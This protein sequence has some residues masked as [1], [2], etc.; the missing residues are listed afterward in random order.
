MAKA[1]RKADD[2]AVE[3]TTGGSYEVRF[4]ND[5]FGAGA[6]TLA[7]LLRDI[8]GSDEPR[9]MLVADSNVVQRAEGLGM[10][11]G[12][13]VQT[14]GVRLAGAPVVIGG[15][16][17]VKCDCSQSL[18]K[19][20][21]AAVEARIGA[22]DAMVVIG[23]G[24]VTD[25]ASYVAVQTRG[26][27]PIVRIPT[28]VAAMVDGAFSEYA[29]I[30]LAGVKDA[31]RIPCRPSG[32]VID[33]T[34]AST[35]L[36]G[37]WRGGIG[38][39]IRYAAAKDA[40]LFKKIAKSVAAL[41]GRDMEIMSEFVHAVV[42]SRVKNGGTEMALWCANRLES[43]SNYKLPHGYAIPIAMCID[44]AYAAARG[45]MSES[46]QELVCRTLAESGALDGLPHSLYLL[47]QPDS[48]LRG[49]DAWRLATGSS[50]ITIPSG[51]G[52]TTVEEAPDR[53]VFDKVVRGFRAASKEE[54]SED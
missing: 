10:K 30:N 40:A 54:E 22:K 20:M 18:Q 34:F 5:A 19:M 31:I 33:T 47:D 26:G 45:L 46:E 12:K 52:K 49:L 28:T 8:T 38:E 53:S 36:D 4:A 1:A 32:I 39:M 14:T 16:E 2:M 13:F 6:E 24:S 21:T 44:C 9:M 23:G 27:L 29:A 50:A 35:V 42:E 37:V 41:K 17:K 7:A 11:I 25:I 51:I 48:I 15:G 43:M 3:W